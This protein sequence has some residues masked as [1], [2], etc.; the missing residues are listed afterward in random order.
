L[1]TS[2][3]PKYVERFSKS[4]SNSS[5][6]NSQTF[7]HLRDQSQSQLKVPRDAKAIETPK[8]PS[9]GFNPAV[10]RPLTV[11]P[12]KRVLGVP[13]AKEINELKAQSQRV[14]NQ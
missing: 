1:A 11:V 8:L 3:P 5:L 4:A 7:V 2:F 10:F 6:T 13:F 12:I 9:F 14:N